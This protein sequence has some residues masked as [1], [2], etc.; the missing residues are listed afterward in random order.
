VNAT[1]PDDLIS[2][3]DLARERGKRKQAIFKVA[4]R[5]G[6]EP[7][8][9]RSS[10]N[11]GQ[12]ISYLTRDEADRVLGYMNNGYAQREIST[13]EELNIEPMSLRRA[14]ARTPQP[15]DLCKG[16]VVIRFAADRFEF[17]QDRSP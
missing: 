14:R 16:R 6:I 8:K 3:V 10:S 5:L 15:L 17:I 12:L 13:A 9:L 1:S 7:Q 4:I 2:V 11:G